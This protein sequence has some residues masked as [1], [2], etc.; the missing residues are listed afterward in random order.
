MTAVSVSLRLGGCYLPNQLPPSQPGASGEHL[1]SPW[2]EAPGWAPPESYEVMAGSWSLG[3]S[4]SLPH[5]P[6]GFQ[7]EPEKNGTRSGRGREGRK[8]VQLRLSGLWSLP[9]AFLLPSWVSLGLPLPG[10]P[11]CQ[12]APGPCSTT[13]PNRPRPGQRWW[14]TPAVQ[15]WGAEVGA[16]LEPM[17]SRPAW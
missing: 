6:S 17:R 11:G 10:S 14:P 9:E 8:S 2:P 3:S 7:A 16:S 4:A 15:H 5:S 12:E 13:Y 1:P